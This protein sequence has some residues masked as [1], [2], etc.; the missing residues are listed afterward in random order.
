[1]RTVLDNPVW[2]STYIQFSIAILLYIVTLPV[3]LC[4]IIGAVSVLSNLTKEVLK[5]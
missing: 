3:I 4:V 2:K 1:M 5:K